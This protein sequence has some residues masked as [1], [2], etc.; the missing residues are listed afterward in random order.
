MRRGMGGC[1]EEWEGKV[2]GGRKEE[3]AG[4]GKRSRLTSLGIDAL[5]LHNSFS[6][7]LTWTAR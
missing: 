1:K 6:Y 2:D 3:E 7:C 5:N 4:E